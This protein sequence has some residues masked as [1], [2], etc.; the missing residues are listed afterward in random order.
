QQLTKTA[1]DYQDSA[2]ALA[3][4]HKGPAAQAYSQA[5]SDFS[6]TVA[7]SATHAQSAAKAMN[8][9][10]GVVGTTRGLIRDSLAQFAGDALVKYVAASAL[11]EVT[12]GGSDAAFIVD[13]VAE[14]ASLAAKCAG[15]LSKVAEALDKLGTHASKS[16]ET[17][18]K[19][20]SKLAKASEKADK[21]ADK[22]ATAAAKGSKDAKEA[23]SATK[24]EDFQKKADHFNDNSVAKDAEEA[25]KLNAERG[26]LVDER[27]D[28]WKQGLQ[29]RLFGGA[30][31]KDSFLG[32]VQN[33]WLEPEG[34]YKHGVHSLV[35]H[36]VDV[37]H[38]GTS[39][40]FSDQSTRE[41]DIAGE[42]AEDLEKY[43]K[44]YPD[45]N[46]SLSTEV[47]FTPTIEPAEGQ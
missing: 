23:D 17:L 7:A 6:Q 34:E 14:G 33:R 18:E 12:F 38:E 10:G 36:V 22:A 13:E 43:E 39:N 9:A 32:K 8:F 46:G 28:A 4:Q 15:K 5:A 30:P 26:K 37:A 3:Q 31:S 25:D 20:G 40:A 42:S 44:E 35:G 29:E 16:A 11:T 19:A 27:V 1:G 24:L 41:G 21:G 45:Y 2:N 47:S